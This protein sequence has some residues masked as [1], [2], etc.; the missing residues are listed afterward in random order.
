MSCLKCL[1]SFVEEYEIVSKLIFI[2]N[3]YLMNIVLYF[4]YPYTNLSYLYIYMH[5]FAIRSWVELPGQHTKTF[6]CG[7]PTLRR[8][9]D[10]TNLLYDN[11]CF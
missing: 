8:I 9:V 7:F 3:F 1:N 5:C 4:N 11:N 2:F 6:V 10:N